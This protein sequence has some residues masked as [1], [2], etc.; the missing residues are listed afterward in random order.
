MT[1]TSVSVSSMTEWIYFVIL[2][3][4]VG[5]ISA[6]TVILAKVPDAK[7]IVNKILPFKAMIGVAALAVGIINLLDV[8]GSHMFNSAILPFTLVLILL[9]LSGFMLGMPQIAKWVPGDAAPEEKA[10][11]LSQKLVKFDVPM[12]LGLIGCAV[13]CAL[14]LMSM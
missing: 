7:G 6:S 13:W 2:P 5:V 12:G 14:R 9:V 10:L 8:M 11:E 4:V 1:E 3:L